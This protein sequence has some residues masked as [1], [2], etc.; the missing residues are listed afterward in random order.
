[1]VLAPA[2]PKGL[3]R[4]TNGYQKY[5]LLKRRVGG[6]KEMQEVKNFR[7]E[8]DMEIRG[9]IIF[10]LFNSNYHCLLIKIRD[11]I[12]G[13]LETGLADRLITGQAE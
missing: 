7:K 12:L 5:I 2:R 9:T 11:Y 10:C 3:I 8:V 4:I 6:K 1:M 13:I